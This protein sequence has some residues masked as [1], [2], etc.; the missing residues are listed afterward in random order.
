MNGKHRHIFL[1]ICPNWFSNVSKKFQ[2][3]TVIVWIQKI[4]D[5]KILEM[6][7]GF[8]SVPWNKKGQQRIKKRLQKCVTTQK[9]DKWGQ[10][11][12]SILRQIATMG[13]N[14]EENE[15]HIRQI[16]SSNSGRIA[17]VRLRTI[18]VSNSHF[19]SQRHL[20]PLSQSAFKWSANFLLT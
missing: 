12:H 2:N 4:V 8:W 14:E 17:S 1:G 15:S 11:L 9:N 3:C 18:V 20:F 13:K 5:S 16:L 19:C 10:N 6:I 7:F